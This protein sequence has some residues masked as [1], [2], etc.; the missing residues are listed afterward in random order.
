MQKNYLAAVML[1]FSAVF[2]GAQNTVLKGVITQKNNQQPL[3][4]ANV[5]F[6]GTTTGTASNNQGEFQMKRLKPGT[7]D[8]V[9]SFSGFKR[10]KENITLTAGVNTF[11]FEMEE[12][13]NNLGEVVVT[14]TGTPHHLKTAPVLTELISKKAIEST[15]AADFTELM[16]N[17][18]PSFDFNPGV[19]GSSMTINGLGNDFILVLVDGKR[20]YGDI[21]GNN[22]LNRINP[23]DIERIEVLKGAASLLY[24]SDAIAGVVNI[25]TKKSK[26]T[27]N[28]SNT[29][30][31]REYATI[32]QSNSI[33]L[34]LGKLSWNG[35]FN[36][37]SSNG[38]K[39]SQYELDDNEL[40][41][42]DAMTQN[43]YNDHTFSHTLTFRATNKLELYAGNSVYE[44]DATMPTTVKK[45]GYFYDDKT[46]EAGAKF[47]LN[48]K[49]FISLGY[50]Y[51]RFRYYYRYNQDYKDYVDGDKSINNDQRMNNVRL[52]YVNKLSKINKLTLG[53]DYLQEKMVS[54]ARLVGGEAEANTVALY[55]QD[56]ITF[57]KNLDVVAGIRAVKHK[58]FGSAFTP[59]VSL[60]YK[61]NGFNLRGTYGHG[62][63][64]PT[65]K[66]LYYAYEKR[67]TLYMGNENLDPQKS[68]FYSAAIEYNSK[69]L[70]ASLTAYVNNV[71][72]L[73][74]YQT[75]DALPVDA[76]NGIKKRRQHYNV[77]ESRSQGFDILLNAKLGAG[78]TIGGGY[79]CVDAK[80]L[81]ADERLDGVAQNYGNLRASYD[82]SW[83]SYRFNA[84]VLGRLQDEKSYDNGEDNAKAYNIWK[85]TTNHRF[86][87]IGYIIFKAQLGIDNIFDYV[88]DSPYGSH[89]GTIS[90]GRTFFAGLTINFA[91]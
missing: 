91:Q 37:K 61:L 24:G 89:Y 69:F 83:K 39:N 47:L 66:E 73:I 68:Q 21:G 4:G 34:N 7:Y 80:D 55:A 76:D 41:E 62:F 28:I 25:I 9:I 6:S 20:M 10:I 8:L 64:A 53:A 71:D 2:A 30:R 19:M 29:T 11:N 46:F 90:P 1:L 59:K 63:K 78:F 75:I 35:N 49:D 82:H 72:D 74:A 22:D 88:D 87:N 23:D 86:A 85:L 13:K 33:D 15:A 50:N 70:S 84:N 67:G 44:R 18:S 17:V 60:L 65:V 58:E 12:S 56:E 48:R 26:Q 38:W 57:V 77:E 31:V 45:Y 40:V 42:T 51:D 32:Q 36:H 16:L 81:I 3:P 52:K 54:E 5:Y 14:G 43:K 79:S 27:L